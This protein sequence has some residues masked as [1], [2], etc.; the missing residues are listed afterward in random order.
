MR[1]RA[2]KLAGR[3]AGCFVIG[4]LVVGAFFM[5]GIG[6]QP[7]GW[8]LAYSLGTPVAVDLS[9]PCDIRSV[10]T[11]SKVGKAVAKCQGARWTLDGATRTGTLYCYGYDISGNLGAAPVFTGEAR[12]F[13]GRAYGR[14]GGLDLVM[15][16]AAVAVAVACLVGC[17]AFTVAAHRALRKA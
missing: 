14:P 6:N 15:G 1:V 2:E 5:P 17:I 9:G 8:G 12:S 11:S 10:R 3:A 4:G 13:R 16:F 7:K